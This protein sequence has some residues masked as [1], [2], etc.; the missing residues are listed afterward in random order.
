MKPSDRRQGWDCGPA[1]TDEPVTVT[2]P[3]G[4]TAQKGTLVL[5]L[6]LISVLLL[7][8]ALWSMFRH[9]GMKPVRRSARTWGRRAQTD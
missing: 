9:G 5:A 6:A 7:S 3:T 4:K 1:P 8:A 2:V